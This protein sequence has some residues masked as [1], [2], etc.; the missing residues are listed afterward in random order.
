[1]GTNDSSINELKRGDKSFTKPSDK[2][3]LLNSHFASIGPNLASALPNGN[4][5]F[6]SYIT[7]ANTTFTLHHTTAEEVLRLL[8]LLSPNKATGLDNIPCRLL[9]EGAPIISAYLASIINKTIDTGLFPSNWKIAK[10]FPLF[11]ANDRTD[12]QNY[13]PISVLPAI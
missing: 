2:C 9:K 11:K 5:N 4:N 6:E 8:K 7:P 1:M 13:R 3:E 12:P 10:I